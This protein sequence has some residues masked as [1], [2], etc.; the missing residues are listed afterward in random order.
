MR[1]DLPHTLF[2]K[3]KKKGKKGKS[4]ENYK[5]NPDDKAVK[6]QQEAIR[7]KR[8]RMVA[9]G[10]EVQYTVDELFRK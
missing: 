10:K 2:N 3:K 6:M 4:N 1:S 9:E 5:Y 7:R 8:E